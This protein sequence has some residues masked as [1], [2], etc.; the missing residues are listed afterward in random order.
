M[1]I[2]ESQK[3]SQA[4]WITEKRKPIYYRGSL[5]HFSKNAFIREPLSPS[6]FFFFLFSVLICPTWIIMHPLLAAVTSSK[7]TDV[8]EL[9]P[10]SMCLSHSYTHTHNYKSMSHACTDTHSHFYR[11]KVTHPPFHSHSL[12][13]THH[14]I[15]TLCVDKWCWPTEVWLVISVIFGLNSS[16]CW[17]DMMLCQWSRIINYSHYTYRPKNTHLNTHICTHIYTQPLYNRPLPYSLISQ[18]N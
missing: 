5:A 7:M 18:H 8:G 12:L 15:H 16:R 1:F 13:L 9:S 10:R 3:I 2:I 14:F 6:S 4:P 11:H 17:H